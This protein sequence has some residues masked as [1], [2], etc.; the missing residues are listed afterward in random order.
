MA[1]MRGGSNN[2]GAIPTAAE[3]NCARPGGGCQAAFPHPRGDRR[4]GREPGRLSRSSRHRRHGCDGSTQLRC[5]HGNCEGG[6]AR[7]CQEARVLS[8]SPL[9]VKYSKIPSSSADP[10]IGDSSSVR[11]ARGGAHGLSLNQHDQEHRR[12]DLDRMV[13]H[14]WSAA[15]RRTALLRP[16][17]S[18]C[19]PQGCPLGRDPRIRC[20]SRASAARHWRDPGFS[21]PWARRAF[22]VCTAAIHAADRRVMTTACRRSST[23]RAEVVERLRG[24]RSRLVEGAPRPQYRSR[25]RRT[26][27]CVAEPVLRRPAATQ[28]PLHPQRR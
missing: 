6:M 3:V 9:A 2:L 15:A 28:R 14:P 23:P 17:A 19:A 12:R 1:A 8:L 10:D 20:R 18:R 27:Q 22:Q 13:P 7:V 21:S 16:A 24:A 11:A 5:P 26:R 4:C 25:P